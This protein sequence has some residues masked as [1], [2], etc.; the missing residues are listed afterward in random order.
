MEV[1]LP[2]HRNMFMYLPHVLQNYLDIYTILDFIQ[3]SQVIGLSVGFIRTSFMSF[4]IGIN[5][6][7]H[8][9]LLVKYKMFMFLG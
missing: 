5:R 1:K 7:Y 6:K 4:Y 8:N 9:V 3:S 2:G